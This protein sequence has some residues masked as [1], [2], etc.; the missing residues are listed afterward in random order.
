[1]IRTL[2]NLGKESTSP[3]VAKQSSA[4]PTQVSRRAFLTLGRDRHQADGKWRVAIDAGR[5]ADCQACVRVCAPGALRRADEETRI[6]YLVVLTSCNGCGDCRSVCAADA[7]TVSRVADRVE[8][9]V[10]IA[11][12]TKKTC[13]CCGRSEAGFMGEICPVCQST[14]GFKALG[15]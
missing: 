4:E 14:N 6:V 15:S 3:R 12:L 2:L 13:L 1:M 9:D 10:Q 8:D 11:S 5:C 7:V